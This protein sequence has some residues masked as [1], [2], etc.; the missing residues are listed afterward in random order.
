MAQAEVRVLDLGN[1]ETL[2]YE[3][4][5]AESSVSARGTATR[6]LR[7]LASGDIEAAAAL[8]NAPQ[9]RL[10]V[11]RD[12]QASVGEA[13]FKRIF[14]EYLRKP[15]V[16]EIAIGERRLI[17]WD[18]SEA[19]SQLAGQFYVRVDGGFLMDDV[20]S[21]ARRDLR[22]VLL[23]YRKSASLSGRKD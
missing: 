18:L 11:L 13:E 4:L 20:P 23:A 8:S 1:G 5:D 17:I 12:Y 16:A 21:D 7:S 2:R 3:V 6:V 15:V 9:R 19:A 10:E 22:R 14:A